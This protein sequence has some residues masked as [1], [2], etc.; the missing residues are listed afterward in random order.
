MGGFALNRWRAL[1]VAGVVG[2]VLSSSAWAAGETVV[3]P[4]VTPPVD[5]IN[6]ITKPVEWFNWGA[7]FRLRQEYFDNAIDLLNEYQDRRNAIRMRCRFWAEV[8]PF[9]KMEEL[10]AP[11]GVTANIRMTKETRW[12]Q[13][14]DGRVPMQDWNEIVYDNLYVQ[15]QRILGMPISLKVGRQDLVY[16]KG[17][18]ILDGTPL[19]G[20]RTIY[21]DAVK[22]T[23]HLDNIATTIDVFALDNKAHQSRFRPFDPKHK[24]V[25]EYD[26]EVFGIYAINKTLAPHEFHSYYIYKNE[27]RVA[28]APAIAPGDRTVHTV[29]GLGQGKFA[30]GVDYYA[31]MAG[32]WGTEAG[33]NRVGFGVNS[34]VGYT[35]TK[36]AMTPRVHGGYEY[37]SGDDPHTREYEGWDNVLGRWPQFSEAYAYRWAFEGGRPGAYTNLHRFTLGVNARPMPKMFAVLD[38][39]LL[40]A[41][42]HTFGTSYTLP[43]P[44]PA[45]YGDG[46]VRGHLLVARVHY[47]FTKR[48]TGHMWAEYFCPGSYY[49]DATDDAVFLRWELAYAFKPVN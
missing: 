9:F 6:Q 18:I 11:N 3:P 16:G 30:N 44:I 41:D 38:Y 7:D 12:Y 31:E 45:P 26:T 8:G 15:W 25:S 33:A 48:L 42:E 4:S 43:P 17:W 23:L 14:D 2:I 40:L 21:S 39:S 10:T 47:D 28:A 20:S 46:Y 32:Q 27:N 1:F 36:V 37:L 5:P 24:L 34:D 29:G 49:D 35:F 22:A 19:D 13:Q